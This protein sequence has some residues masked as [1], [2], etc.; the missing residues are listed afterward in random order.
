MSK[1][2]GYLKETKEKRLTV[3]DQNKISRVLH[4]KMP[5]KSADRWEDPDEFVT[6]LVKMIEEFDNGKNTV[7]E[8]SEQRARRF[9]NKRSDVYIDLDKGTSTLEFSNDSGR[10]GYVHFSFYNDPGKNHDT[11]YEMSFYLN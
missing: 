6:L 4:S 7:D 3:V 8:F 5:K 2:E 10:K 1:Y 9:Q 11:R